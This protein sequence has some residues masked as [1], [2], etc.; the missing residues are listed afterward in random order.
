M[1][2]NTQATDFA[3]FSESLFKTEAEMP[4]KMPPAAVA[5]RLIREATKGALGTLQASDKSP[6][7]SMVLVATGLDGAP[8]MLLSRLALHTKNLDA[9]NRAS[10]LIDATDGLGDPVTGARLSLTGKILPATG[11]DVRTRFLARHPA[12]AGYADFG[13]FAFYR[14][15]AVSA[16]LIEGFGRIV[17]IPGPGLLD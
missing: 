7:V 14:F 16:H 11:P 9:D 10:L 5:K 8:T 3:N 4:E 6:Y 15:D 1:L 13:D 17:D 12:A 2:N